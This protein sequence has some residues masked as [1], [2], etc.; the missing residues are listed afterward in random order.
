MFL[1]ALL[2]ILLLLCTVQ[3]LSAATIG[4]IERPPFV[5]RDAD[6]TL[7]GFSIDLYTE[8]ARRMGDDAQPDW[9][10]F[11]V[12]GDM[13]AAARD[14]TIDGAIA[15]ITISA[16]RER[17]LD[18]SHPIYDSGLHIMTRNE[19]TRASI[20]TTI[21]ASGILWFIGGAVLLLL[22]IAHILWFFERNVTDKRHDYFRDDYVGGI[23][24]AF[25]WAFIIMTM[26]GFENEVPHKVISRILAMT[27]IIA[28][29]FFIST[30]TAKIT[31]A[32]TVNEL[33]SDIA[34][35][36]DL[37]NRRV[38]T[39]DSDVIRNYLMRAGIT[40]RTFTDK[41]ALYAALRTGAIDAVV[42]DAPILRYYALRNDDVRIVGDM[43]KPERYGMVFP[44]TPRGRIYK[45]RFN[46]ALLDMREDGTYATIYARYFGT[47]TN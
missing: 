34:A 20:I 9:R 41:G 14:G 40:P 5:M 46:Q 6:G 29:M 28:S 23:W 2:L 35:L 39:M 25:W 42:G 18:F 47:D 22:I 30:L 38:G 12:F 13:L 3:P 4:T 44:Q 43:F 32:L 36:D 10:V 15:N 19:E 8:A 37:V 21:L 45:E 16:D 33:T 31:T 17:V 11:D 24:D 7:R 27:W 26:G 1:R